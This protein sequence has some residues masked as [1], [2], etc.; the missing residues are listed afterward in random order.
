MGTVRQGP[1]TSIGF[2]APDEGADQRPLVEIN[3][4]ETDRQENSG[5]AVGVYCSMC[6]DCHFPAPIDA[7]GFLERKQRTI[8]NGKRRDEAKVQRKKGY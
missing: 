7:V 2:D 5:S 8:R 4:T 1:P 3:L 6:C